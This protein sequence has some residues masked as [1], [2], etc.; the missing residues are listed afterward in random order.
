MQDSATDAY[1]MDDLVWSSEHR[2]I[3]NSRIAHEETKSAMFS[4]DDTKAPGPDGFSSLFF[5]RAWS[6]VG[7][8]VSAVVED[9]FNS[10]CMLREMDC[11]IIALV[12]KVPNPSSIYGNR[13]ISCCNTIYKCISKIIAARI[14][15]CLLDIICPAQTAF[16]HRRSIA[17][18]IFLTQELMKNYY[19]DF[20]PPRCAL[21]I[22]LKKAYDSIRW[23]CILDIL[24][25]IGTP[26]I[27]LR[28]I[29]A[30]ITTPKFSICVN[31]ELTGFF[32]SKR[33]VRQGDP[34]SPFLFLIAMKAFSRSLSK[35]VLH[36]R[37]DFHPK[38]KAINLSHLCFADDIFLFAKGNATSVQITME[39]L[40]KFEAFSGMQV[41]KQKSAVFLVGINDSV[42]ATILNMTGLSLGSLPV[43]YLG[44]PLISSRLSHSDCQPLLDKIM[45][46]IQSW[47]SRSLSFAGRL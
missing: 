13:P 1:H 40:A 44:V 22:D 47:T 37:F 25:A 45:A 12:P 29:K 36:P 28:C 17:D 24:T 16:V 23:G 11:T 15:R 26:S 32:A 18:N 9:F 39:E 38:C 19:Y 27:L 31:G 10:G 41:N 21:K 35:V 46:R 7:S 34:L 30:C 42:K 4:I 3:L 8:E 6:I 14:K 2:D 5:K 43:K 33:G 20:G